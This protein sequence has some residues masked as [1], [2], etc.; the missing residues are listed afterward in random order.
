[1]E[2]VAP[3]DKTALEESIRNGW[4]SWRSEYSTMEVNLRLQ[5]LLLDTD[6]GYKIRKSSLYQLKILTG[7]KSLKIVQTASYITNRT[8]LVGKIATFVYSTHLSKGKLFSK[9]Y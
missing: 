3:G 7:H 1:M 5:E 2:P 6:T 4:R 9:K 8:I